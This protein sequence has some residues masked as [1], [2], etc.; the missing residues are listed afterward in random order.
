[1]NEH[2][3]TQRQTV[4]RRDK[5][6]LARSKMMPSMGHRVTLGTIEYSCHAHH[7]AHTDINT[8]RARTK[9][10]RV[11]IRAERLLVVKHVRSVNSNDVS[12]QATTK[13]KHKNDVGTNN[14]IRVTM[15]INAAALHRAS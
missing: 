15:T 11:L 3:N 12:Y 6:N 7:I 10:S 4:E 1:M 8:I 5:K 14:A 13:Q 9:S 2:I